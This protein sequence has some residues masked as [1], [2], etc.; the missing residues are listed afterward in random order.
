[1]R[2]FV[3]AGCATCQRARE[4]V[5]VVRRLRPQQPVE[6]VDLD[7]V[8]RPMPGGV[9][10]TPTFLLGERIVSLGNPAVAELL[11]TLDGAAS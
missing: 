8:A 1:M 10:G 5:D 2:V 4:L 3:S 7:V 9:V 11:A 6:V